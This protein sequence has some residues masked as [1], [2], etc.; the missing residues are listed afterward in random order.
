MS[1]GELSIATHTITLTVTDERGAS[2]TDNIVFVV[3]LPPVVSIASPVDGSVSNVGS[4][5][6][7]LGSV[8]DPDEEESSLSV[9][10]SSDRD[11]VIYTG[12]PDSTGQTLTTSSSLTAGD[13]AITLTATDALGL[14][15]TAITVFRVNSMPTS[16]T[17]RI[18]PDPATTTDDL[19][20]VFDV[21]S[22][23]LDLDPVAYRFE[24]F[25]GGDL[26][27]ESGTL[28][29]MSTSKHDTW[30]VRVTPYDPF[31]D[32]V[33]TTAS[34]T[35]QN[36]PPTLLS[37]EIGPEEVFTNTLVE[38]SVL[39]DDVDGDVVTLEHSWTVNSVSAGDAAGLLDGT[40]WFNKHDVIELSVT[41][42]DED[43]IG[44]SMD[45]SAVVVQNS[46]PSAATIR[47]SP[48]DAIGGMD[49]LVCE[50]ETPGTDLDGDPILYTLSWERDGD[51]YPDTESDD[52]GASW[53]GPITDEWTDD[54]V[55]AVDTLPEETWEC[56]VTSWD[57][58]EAGGVA[59]DAV[60]VSAPPPG[61]GDGLLQA[62]EEFDPP[63]G[64]F[65]NVSVDAETCR[66]DF[67]DVEQLYCYGFCSWAG[68]PG[69]DDADA[70][71][72]CKLITDNPDSEAITYT[73]TAPLSAPG[74]PGVY[75]G[76]GELIDT[77]RGIPDVAWM[78]ESMA[79]HHGG[80]GQV[81]AFPDCTDP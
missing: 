70:D 28:E 79:A 12:S 53:V 35:I 58:E 19:T 16:P 55:P 38:S 43:D 33:S 26:M 8:A 69:C 41:V 76:Y 67:S 14:T 46:P 32:G 9:V 29:A 78:D 63:P 5:V 44:P 22:V 49:P 61:C 68:P 62:G 20:V 24:W 7:F 2:C 81:V 54:T 34:R 71:V 30:T 66:W 23:D 6:T 25:K 65:L 56:T 72:L 59:V 3:G 73:V 74:F 13:H 40:D 51:A 80:G 31:G 39:F 45:A 1:T 10:W 50:I 64:P 11:G 42:A 4:V 18:S 52:T 15:A 60:L 75:C 17:V 27:V 48:D 36:T 47:V 21:D 77:D 57:D 37:V